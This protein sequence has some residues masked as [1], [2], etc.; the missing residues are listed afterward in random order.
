MNHNDHN[1]YCQPWISIHPKLPLNKGS[2]DIRGLLEEYPR[3]FIN[4]G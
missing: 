1:Q 4:H 2:D 3:I